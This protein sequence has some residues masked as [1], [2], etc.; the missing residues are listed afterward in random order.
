M[1]GCI[2]HKRPIAPSLVFRQWLCR[3]GYLMTPT[4]AAYA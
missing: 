4:P 1:G 3:A 2:G